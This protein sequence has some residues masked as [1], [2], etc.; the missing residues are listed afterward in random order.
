M[1][2]RKTEMFNVNT[3][4]TERY[5]KKINNTIHAKIVK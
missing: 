5:K 4:N 2:L 1:E 3:A